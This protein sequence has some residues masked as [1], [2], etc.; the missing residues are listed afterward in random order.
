M[1]EANPFDGLERR[2][3]LVTGGTGFIGTRLVNEL[4]HAGHEVIVL[5]RDPRRAAHQFT[6]RTRCI[7]S[8]T[9]L[10]VGER[11]DAVINLAGAPVVGPRWSAGRKAGLL[12]SRVGTTEA[13]V[14]WVAMARHKPSVWIQASAIGYYGVRDPSESLDEASAPGV[15]FMSEL[16][17]RWEAAARPVDAMGIRQV[18]LR[19][20]VVVGRGGALPPLVLPFRLGFG[21]RLG[22]GRQVMS[23]IHLED[24][25]ALIARGLHDE[26]MHGVYNA[27]A[28]EAITQAEFAA[29]VG[30]I[31]RRPVWFHLPAAPIRW[32]GGE[33]AQLFV[34]GQRVVPARL[35]DSGYRFRF[36]ILESA[37]AN[38]LVGRGAA[39]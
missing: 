34:D 2:R 24:V 17:V 35:R 15:G 9:E 31:L 14:Q 27:V 25:L 3:I 29:T 30:R 7:Q 21:G 13:L 36:P 33:M 20:G 1:P 6:R 23:W 5:T 8:M 39:R 12:R 37:L 4:L 19:L 28:P 16:C 22:T 38:T 18:I 26:G 32:L 10:D 11:I